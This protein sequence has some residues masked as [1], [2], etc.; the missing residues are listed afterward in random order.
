MD[1]LDEIERQADTIPAGD[2]ISANFIENCFNRN[3]QYKQYELETIEE[4]YDYFLDKY[5][6]LADAVILELK[7][8]LILEIK[9]LKKIKEILLGGKKNDKKI[10]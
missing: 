1:Y 2:Y 7:Q 5:Q 6:E 9:N 4:Y 3:I 8:V 10:K